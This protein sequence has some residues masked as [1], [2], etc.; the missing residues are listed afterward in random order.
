MSTALGRRT[1][2]GGLGAVARRTA[3]A[4]LAIAA[5]AGCASEAQLLREDPAFTAGEIRSGGIAVLGVVQVDE[6][7]QARPPLIDALERV[8]AGAR[9]DIPFARAARVHAAL[10]DSATR[11]LLLG[12]QLRGDP[13]SIWLARA[14]DA[15]RPMARYGVLARVEETRVRYGTREIPSSEIT[16]EGERAVRI[17]GR[18]VRAEVSVYDLASRVLVYRGKFI[19]AS[20]AAPI[21]RPP[22]RDTLNPDSALVER[23]PSWIERPQT[24]RPGTGGFPTPGPSDSPSDLGY[25]DAPPVARAAEGAFLT[26]VRSLPGSPPVPAKAGERPGDPVRR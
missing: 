3:L 4:A 11:L 20:D 18:D 5:A 16:G 1:R 24:F 12:Y 26:F 10:G 14:A 22:P 8:L 7:T 15:A 19:G 2:R 25:P 21:Y 17:T 9:P 13:D 23:R 6:V